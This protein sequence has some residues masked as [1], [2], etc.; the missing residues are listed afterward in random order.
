[1]STPTTALLEPGSAE[2][3][4]SPA[5]ASESAPRVRCSVT[6]SEHGHSPHFVLT[7]GN[8]SVRL[9]AGRS[10]THTD[11]FKWVTRGL[12]EPPQSFVVHADGTVDLNAETFHPDA[13]G[14]AAALEAVLNHRHAI[15]APVSVAARPHTE[16][17]GTPSHRV[18][19]Q[20][21]LDPL[22]HLLVQATR[23]KEKVETGLRGLGHFITEGWML[24][25]RSIHVDP[26]QRYVEIDGVRFEPTPGG[27]DALQAHLNAHCVPPSHASGSA[28]IEIRESAAA[29]T[30]F[31][32][33]FGISRAGTSFE[34]K[35]HLA[36]DKLDILQDHERCDLLRP[37]ILIRLSPPFLYFRRRR[38]DG[39]EEHLTEIPDVKYRGISA[40]ELQ[41]LFNHPAIRHGLVDPPLRH[42]PTDTAPTPPPSLP[43]P[44]PPPPAS[45]SI[46]AP[47]PPALPPTASASPVPASTNSASNATA[48]PVPNGLT[49]ADAR[50][51]RRFAALDP[52]RVHEAIFQRV[53]EVMGLSVQHL[54]LSLPHVFADRRFAVASLDGAEVTSVLQLRGGAFH[55]LYLTHLARER[56]D[57]VYAC[58]GLHLEWGTRTCA[59]QTA[60]GAESREFHGP[61]LRGLGRNAAQEFVFVVDPAYRTWVEPQTAAC[62]A[63]QARFL[64][65]EEW[66]R[67]AEDFPLL[68]PLSPTE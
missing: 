20:V 33:H 64:T 40:P 23:G 49:G 11:H 68:W 44:L 53:V 42:E 3:S 1:M 50:R 2:P 22:G 59:I 30:G 43:P 52:Y 24:A 55:G 34:I 10:W 47:P 36:Q 32:I 19:F 35:G 51:L 9:E 45:P 48:A 39:G 67:H 41:K 21:H 38:P 15:A 27:A 46:T 37:E 54:L 5:H 14:Q 18:H 31:D 17:T 65:P 66:A 8:E 25:P 29:S 7:H 13:A 26:L 28:D 56:I 4:A 60:V 58:R 57:L 61:A 63:A 12:I 6:G 62:A 16:A